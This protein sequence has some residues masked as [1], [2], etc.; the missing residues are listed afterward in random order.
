MQVKVHPYVSVDVDDR[1]A[2]ILLKTT[3][4][5]I[6]LVALEVLREHFPIDEIQ[7]NVYKV[8]AAAWNNE[9]CE[10]VRARKPNYIHFDA[11]KVNGDTMYDVNV[12]C[13]GGIWVE[14]HARND[15][16]AVPDF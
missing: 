14:F 7:V 2:C 10:K 9:S 6:Y 12:A 16:P 13:D 8:N 11:A 4:G 1:C 3:G 5:T 15:M